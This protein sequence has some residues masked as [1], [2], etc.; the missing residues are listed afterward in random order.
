MSDRLCNFLVVLNDG[1][2]FTSL[3]GCRIVEL[4]DSGSKK[5]DFEGDE[6][7]DLE[8]EDIQYEAEILDFLGTPDKPL[9]IWDK[10]SS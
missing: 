10:S 6:L 7:S 3:R 2:T 4:S 1:E 8:P 9:L 5:L